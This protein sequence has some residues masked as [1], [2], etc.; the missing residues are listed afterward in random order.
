[1]TDTIIK[2]LKWWLSPKAVIFE[3]F[4]DF[5]LGDTLEKHRVFIDNGADILFV[6]HLDTVI[7]AKF[8]RNRKTKS[9]KLERVYARGLDDRLGCA[10]AYDL[11]EKLGADLLLTDYEEI[12]KST[13]QYHNLKDYNWIV[14]FDREG[15]DVVT[16]G[17]DSIEFRT[18]LSSYWKI[19]IGSFSDIVSLD[20]NI[21]CMNLGIGHRYSHSKDSY[22][23]IKTLR[24]QVAAFISFYDE[25]KNVKFVQ[26]FKMPNLYD[27]YGV[28][29]CDFC[30]HWLG[31]E[32]YGYTICESCFEFM[33]EQAMYKQE[34]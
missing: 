14:E 29:L 12:C 25:Y 18:A 33:I 34:I 9:G 15:D 19:G 24:K 5:I 21:C 6:A 20:T 28:K 32:I 13:A 10:I 4:N 8:I 31:D 17:L 1:L 16:Y 26:D 11:S 3:H 30:G 2:N 7:P 23:C 27:T 22:V